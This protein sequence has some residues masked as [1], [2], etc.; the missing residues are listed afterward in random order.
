MWYLWNWSNLCPHSTY[1][2]KAII[3]NFI[4]SCDIHIEN[5]R[6]MLS[7]PLSQLV[8]F[9]RF[10]YIRIK[11]A[12]R[13][14]LFSFAFHR[15]AHNHM[16][17]YATFVS[18]WCPILPLILTHTLL[19]LL[20]CIWLSLPFH[21]P[22]FTPFSCCIGFSDNPYQSKENRLSGC[23]VLVPVHSPSRSLATVGSLQLFVQY[24]CSCPPYLKFIYCIR[25]MQWW[26]GPFLTWI[27]NTIVK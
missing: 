4:L 25:N 10:P 1:T 27:W 18:I 16:T 26:A 15:K 19:L 3:W 5:N 11:N 24:Y 9:V 22:N 7:R 21:V 2:V 23:G 20:Q 6:S 13:N 17:I 12:V 14:S 8:I